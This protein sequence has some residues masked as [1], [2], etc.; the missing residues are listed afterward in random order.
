MRARRY[1]ISG[2]VQGV[3]YR[4][5]AVRVARELGLKGWVRNLSDGRVEVYAAGPA[6]RLEDFEARLRQGPP[7]GEVRG[8]EVE[9]SSV[10]ARIEGFDIR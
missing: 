1:L 8:V 3:G 4:F 5:F 2:Q 6:R 10:D 9:Y 7:A